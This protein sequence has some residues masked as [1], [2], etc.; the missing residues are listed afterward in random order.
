MP[1]AR[2][3]DEAVLSVPAVLGIAPVGVQPQLVA[4]AV[5]IQQV[6]VTVRVGCTARHPRHHPANTFGVVF[7]MEPLAHQHAAPSSFTF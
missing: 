7:H 2:A 3:K 1:V 6:R 5:E 4:V